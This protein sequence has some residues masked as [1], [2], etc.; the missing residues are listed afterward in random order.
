MSFSKDLFLVSLRP[1]Y[2]YYLK[3]YRSEL[4]ILNMSEMFSGHWYL[5]ALDTQFSCCSFRLSST[6][7]LSNL[8]YSKCQGSVLHTSRLKQ[9]LPLGLGVSVA[10]LLRFCHS[11]PKP[12]N[13]NQNVVELKLDRDT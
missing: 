4:D 2:Y 10:F 1:A 6:V 9:P 7:V 5:I 13:N 11:Y 3:S 8:V 12:L